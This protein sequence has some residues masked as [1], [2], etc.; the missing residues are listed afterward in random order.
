[1]VRLGSLHPVCV[2]KA[3]D[4]EADGKVERSHRIED[5]E[6]YRLLDGVVVDHTARFNAKLQ[7]REHF[8]NFERPHSALGGHTPYERLDGSPQVLPVCVK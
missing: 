7:E 8:H 1:V 2:H 6:F 3:R 4:P 5:E